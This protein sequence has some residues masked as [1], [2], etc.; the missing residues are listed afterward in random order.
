MLQD[1]ISAIVI[2]QKK[3]LLV[4]ARDSDFYITPGGR[5][6]LNESHYETL[7]RELK[8]ELN[9]EVISAKPY[10]SYSATKEYS[11]KKQ[12]V[13]CYLVTI[14]GDISVSSE[15]KE[16]QWFAIENLPRVAKGI[17]FYVIPRLL[18]NSLL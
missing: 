3:I 12:H 11:R 14:N 17:Q 15:I 7:T 8:E 16:F 10:L 1:R 4:R 2:K 13:Y 5:I 9:V 6:E 18:K